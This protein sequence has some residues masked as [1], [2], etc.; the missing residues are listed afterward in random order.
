[1]IT[2]IKAYHGIPIA[3][4]QSRHSGHCAQIHGHNWSFIFEFRSQALSP[5]GFVIDFGDLKWLKEL[6]Y[7]WDHACLLNEDDPS[8]QIVIDTGVVN[9]KVI[10]DCSCEGIAKYL[11]AKVEGEVYRRTNCRVHLHSIVVQED[12]NNSVKYDGEPILL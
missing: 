1:M 12:A 2:A 10:P 3:H 4:R 5:A 9:V 11:F 6:I 7:E 8:L